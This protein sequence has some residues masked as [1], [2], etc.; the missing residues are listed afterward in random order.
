MTVKDQL[1]SEIDR[2]D[3]RY[4]GLVYKI[5]CQ[6]PRDPGKAR[7][8]TWDQEI[9]MLFQEISDS[10]GL[11]IR[12]PEKWQQEIRKDRSLTFREA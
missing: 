12:D 5:V 9:A 4:L 2:L 6:F 7:E 8:K 3:E 11:D 1:K 10:G